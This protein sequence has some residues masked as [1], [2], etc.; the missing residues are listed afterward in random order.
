MSGFSIIL[1]STSK[2]LMSIDEAL[3]RKIG[4]KVF[5]ILN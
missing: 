4:G 5:C 1:I 3:K 2:G